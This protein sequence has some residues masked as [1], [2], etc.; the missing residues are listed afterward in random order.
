MPTADLGPVGRYV[1]QNLARIRTERGLNYRQLS[2]R[3]RQ[4]GRPIPTLGLSR[5]ENG[6]RRVDADDLVALCIAL[7]VGPAALLLPADADEDEVELTG[8]VRVSG[9]AARRWAAGTTPLPAVDVITWDRPA[10]IVQLREK[11]IEEMRQ[12]LNFHDHAEAERQRRDEEAS[13][14]REED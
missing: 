14:G 6:N 13:R 10:F 3:L 12:R 8:K 2:D 9:Y 11:E 1:V 5:I 7:E 4:I